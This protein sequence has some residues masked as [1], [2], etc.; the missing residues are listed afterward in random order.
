MP[1]GSGRWP[2]LFMPLPHYVGLHEG[3]FIDYGYAVSGICE[4]REEQARGEPGLRAGEHQGGTRT[5]GALPQ[6]LRLLYLRP[7]AGIGLRENR[8]EGHIQ[9]D[10]NS[11]DAIPA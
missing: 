11:P 3:R 9:G 6:A 7:P 4:V 10:D 5:A 2:W 8:H 1:T